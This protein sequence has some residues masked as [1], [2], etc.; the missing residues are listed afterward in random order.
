MEAG[1]K[2]FEREIRWRLLLTKEPARPPAGA[3]R[4]RPLPPKSGWFGGVWGRIHAPPEGFAA[5]EVPVPVFH[6]FLVSHLRE[7]LNPG[8]PLS[9][10]KDLP[11]FPAFRGDLCQD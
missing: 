11:A 5:L 7:W 8:V 3:R 1:G 6:P 2:K 10:H 9:T 4:C